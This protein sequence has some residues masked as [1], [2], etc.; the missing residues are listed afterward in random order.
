MPSITTFTHGETLRESWREKIKYGFGNYPIDGWGTSG[1]VLLIASQ[2]EQRKLYH[3]L[4]ANCYLNNRNVDCN[5]VEP[6]ITTLTNSVMPL[7]NYEIGDLIEITDNECC[8]GRNLKT[9]RDRKYL[10]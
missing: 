7:I 9:I 4:E 1:E 2:C 8:C 5:I 3:I 6:S 10:Y